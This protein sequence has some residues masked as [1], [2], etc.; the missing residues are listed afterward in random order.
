MDLDVETAH[1]GGESP[2][3][4]WL[5]ILVGVAAVAAAMIATLESDA[6]RREERAF[7]RGSRLSLDLF[8]RIAGSGPRLSFQARGL[9]QAL[10]LQIEAQARSIAALD[11][12]SL[13]AFE[14]ARAEAEEAA[15][16]RLAGVVEAMARLPDEASGVDAHTR[17]VL[18]S[19]PDR[20]EDLV[21]AQNAA[22]DDAERFGTRQDRAIFAL[23]LV[24]IAAVLLGLAGVMGEGRSGRT[25]L[26]AAA[27]ALTLALGW[28]ATALPL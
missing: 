16:L 2:F 11:A 3:R 22:I 17:E 5:A 27:V 6:N 9:E 13:A 15:G 12:P 28:G 20:L 8:E 24:A 1:E 21:G 25:S 7:I 10:S 23:S 18:A 4:R 14:D 26:I 19:T